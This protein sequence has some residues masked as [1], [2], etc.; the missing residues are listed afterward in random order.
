RAGRPA[1]LRRRHAAVPAAAQR[2]Y[3]KRA[4]MNPIPRLCAFTLTLDGAALSPAL[5][6]CAS[7]AVVRQMLNAPAL[8]EAVFADPP[9]DAA[10]ALRLGAGLT[11]AP[12][13]GD[14]LFDGEVTAIE[15]EADPAGG[16]I[17]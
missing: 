14:P 16:R 2:P 15:V 4:A 13:G 5:A 8:A 11:L 17:L 1:S 3:R 10:G 12:A 6:R 7:S 9:A